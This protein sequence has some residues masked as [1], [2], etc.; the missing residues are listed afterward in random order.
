MKE[1]SIDWNMIWTGETSNVCLP[2]RRWEL[3]EVGYKPGYLQSPVGTEGLSG[4]WR[5]AGFQSTWEANK[6]GSLW[7]FEYAL[8]MG[9][10]NIRRCGLVGGGVALLEEVDFEIS[11]IRLSLARDSLA[12]VWPRC[13]TLSSI[14]LQHLVY[15][16]TAVLH[17]V[18]GL[19]LWDCKL[20]PTKCCSL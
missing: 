8:P 5:A 20:P 7:W 12:V 11:H 19:D 18:N 6:G 13:R 15:L 9:S 2:L 3:G 1:N 16:H 10:G 14:C 4:S 17:D